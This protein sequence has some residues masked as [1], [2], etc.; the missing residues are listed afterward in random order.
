MTT[1]RMV[2]F[3]LKLVVLDLSQT[4]LI[5]VFMALKYK[6]FTTNFYYEF[7]CELYVH[8]FS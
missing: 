8:N 7:F 6:R 5:L 3:I 4:V 2:G 1:L